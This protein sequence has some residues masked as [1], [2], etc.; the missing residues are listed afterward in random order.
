VDPTLDELVAL[1]AE[2][3]ASLASEPAGARA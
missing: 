2:V 1:D 3:R